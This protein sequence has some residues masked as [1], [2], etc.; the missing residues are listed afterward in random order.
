MDELAP[1]LAMG[2]LYNLG[3]WIMFVWV[4]IAAVYKLTQ[5]F[6][7]ISLSSWQLFEVGNRFLYYIGKEPKPREVKIISLHEKSVRKRA[8]LSL[9][10]DSSSAPH[11]RL[12]RRITV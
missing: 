4:I 3:S 2:Q 5:R 12:L 10:S 11:T 1:V 6:Q 7:R 8:L 9:I